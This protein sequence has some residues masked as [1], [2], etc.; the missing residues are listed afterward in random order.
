MINAEN[1]AILEEKKGEN[2]ENNASK[3]NGN[4]E[5]DNKMPI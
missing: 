3:A 2:D 4:N 5:N 1:N